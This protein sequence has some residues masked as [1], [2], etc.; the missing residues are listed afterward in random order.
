LAQEGLD[1]L[2][3]TLGG[4]RAPELSIAN[5]PQ[6]L[7]CT[8]VP[9]FTLHGLQ[10]NVECQDWPADLPVRLNS[11]LYLTV[12]EALT[13]VLKHAQASKADILL[14]ADASELALTIRD[15][16]VGFAPSDRQRDQH[17]PSG[18]G[19]GIENMRERI[20]LLGGVMAV[21]ASPGRGVQ[22][23]FRLPRPGQSKGPSDVGSLA[24]SDAAPW[25]GRS[26]Q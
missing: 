5:L 19:M 3:S 22:I 15:N 18:S 25:D 26:I 2:R 14:F 7:R 11:M 23:E 24:C 12:R 8:L 13:N 4:L 1:A 21:S 6:A 20:T 16:G 10:V 9:Q 17:V